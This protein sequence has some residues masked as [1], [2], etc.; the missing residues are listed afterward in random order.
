MARAII[1][2]CLTVTEVKEQS[3]L[4]GVNELTYTILLCDNLDSMRRFYKRVFPFE[5]QGEGEMT[6]DLA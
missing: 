1:S 3:M 2:T 4:D 6:G 5:V